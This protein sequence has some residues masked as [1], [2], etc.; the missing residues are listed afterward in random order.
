MSATHLGARHHE[1]RVRTLCPWPGNGAPPTR[2][3]QPRPRPGEAQQPRCG[4]EVGS[5]L[6]EVKGPNEATQPRGLLS[7]TWTLGGMAR[8]PSAPRPGRGPPDATG[9]APASSSRLQPPVL[10]PPLVPAPGSPKM[11][12]TPG[13]CPGKVSPA[14]AA[15]L[16]S[17]PP[18]ARAAPPRARRRDVGPPRGVFSLTE[19]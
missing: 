18:A 16:T 8:S 5:W 14:V 11:L 13:R 7:G 6:R 4:R 3:V 19:Q 9:S 1:P 15:V 17:F 10:S 2:I 12:D